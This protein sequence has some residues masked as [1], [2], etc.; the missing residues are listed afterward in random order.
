MG[1]KMMINGYYYG[2]PMMHYVN[3]ALI[4]GIAVFV[5]LVFGVVLFFTFFR[6]KNEGKYTGFRRKLYHFMNFN[7]FY[8]EDILRFV[9]IVSTCVVTI[10]G[11]VTIVLGSF[12][13]GA[14]ELIVINLILR[15]CFELLMMF[16][17][18]CRKT[19]SMDRKLDR[20][21]NYYDGYEA[22]W[23]DNCRTDADCDEADS[24]VGCDGVCQGCSVE[25]CMEKSL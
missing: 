9:Y 8:A 25:G 18:L 10:V 13:V 20:I 15:V 14:M 5:A 16:I 4:L 23:S 12:L 19:V 6:K 7:R 1:S 11:I 21:A 17:I 2:T 22:N 24:V 3:H